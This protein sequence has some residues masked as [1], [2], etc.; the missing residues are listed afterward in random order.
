MAEIGEK[1]SSPAWWFDVLF[2]GV[3]IALFV[4]IGSAFIQPK[5][6]GF[7]VR[8]SEQRKEQAEN[9]RKLIELQATLAIADP[10][11]AQHFYYVA[12]R[13]ELYLLTDLLLAAISTVL[14]YSVD[15]GLGRVIW[16][17]IMAIALWRQN[18]TASEVKTARRVA[19]LIPQYHLNRDQS[20]ETAVQ[21]IQ[22]YL[23][24]Q[25]GTAE[26]EFT[27]VR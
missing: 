21:F 3:L 19:E 6:G 15:F 4:N 25:Q 1:L 2:V 8:R 27:Q 11:L 18:K 7:F 20:R 12:L 16:L 13:S 26:D 14:Y 24:R 10:V 22:E 23:A 5:I 9:R 17:V